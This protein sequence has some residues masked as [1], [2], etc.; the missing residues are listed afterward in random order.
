MLTS[1]LGAAD[2]MEKKK[3]VHVGDLTLSE[4]SQSG[5]GYILCDSTYVKYLGKS[6]S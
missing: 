5:K 4:M 6:K 3:K 2:G 1:V